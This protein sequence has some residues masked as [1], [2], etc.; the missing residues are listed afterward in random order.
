[1]KRTLLLLKG[2]K[3]T[4]GPT[5]RKLPVAFDDVKVTHDAL[6]I[7]NNIDNRILR[8]RILTGWHF[9]LRMGE[10]FATWKETAQR[11]L[12]RMADIG[13][14]MDGARCEWGPTVNGVSICISGHKSDWANQ[15]PTRSHSRIAPWGRNGHL[16][17]FAALL[18]LRSAYR[19]KFTKATDAPFT[20]WGNGD[21]APSQYVADTLRSA[22]SKQGRV[23][24]SYSL[25]ALRAGGATALY[26]AAR[27][28]ELVARFGR[29]RTASISSYLWESDQAM[30]GLSI[31]MLTGG[32]TQH[33]PTRKL[34]TPFLLQRRPRR[35]GRGGERRN[36]RR[37]KPTHPDMDGEKRE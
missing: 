29:W 31:L 4:K 16:C 33:L 28:I 9:A 10:Y 35:G 13:P 32:H 17:V 14:L 37:K 8:R 15:R 19:A 25:H 7:E 1:M 27:D 20:S 23:A 22:A 18:E 36:A 24:A 5:N 2:E 3:R 12:M 11:H 21:T 26:R 6:D 30:A 34:E